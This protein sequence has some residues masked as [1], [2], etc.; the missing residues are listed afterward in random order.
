MF[1][2]VRGKTVAYVPG[3][4]FGKPVKKMCAL[5]TAAKAKCQFRRLP[6][7]LEFRDF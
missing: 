4:I 7:T 6:L 3:S 2:E 1:A 5:V